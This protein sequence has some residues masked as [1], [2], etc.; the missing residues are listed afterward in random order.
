MRYPHAGGGQIPPGGICYIFCMRDGYLIIDGHAHIFPDQDV[1]SRIMSSFN[2]RFSI[3]FQP[4]G[5]GTPASLLSDM[6]QAGI[7]YT[8]LANFASNRFLHENNL[9]TLSLA[10]TSPALVPLVSFSPALLQDHNID[11]LFAQYHALGARGIKL[12]PMAQEFDPADSAI[13]PVYSLAARHKLPVVFHCGRV[14]NARLNGWADYQIL[15]PLIEAFGET[16]FILTHMVDGSERDL[17]DAVRF[18]NVCFD[19]SIVLSGY[20]RILETNEPSWRNDALFVSL[21]RELGADR[22]VFGS[23]HP[24]G[25]AR[26]D[27]ERFLRMPLAASEKRAIL[28]ENARR[29]F[30]IDGQGQ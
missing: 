20:D 21:V 30:L 2:E 4:A 11:S 18:E 6:R 28:G 9:W 19:T 16:T 3:A 24:W 10:S 13:L 26:A 22:F 1:S 29:L 27:L 14:A 17:R 7:D 12:H 5:D 15:L 8:I 25:S 23:D